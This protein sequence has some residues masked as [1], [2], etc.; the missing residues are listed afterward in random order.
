MCNKFAGPMFAS[1]RRGNTAPFEEMSQE[2]RDRGNTVSDLIGT[3]FKP[4]TPAAKT[5]TLPLDQQLAFS[6]N[7]LSQN[8]FVYGKNRQSKKKHCVQNS[9]SFYNRASLC[10][11]HF[12]NDFQS[13]QFYPRHLAAPTVR[14]T[15]QKH[16]KC[17]W[18]FTSLQI[19]HRHKK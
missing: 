1:L 5:D 13:L 7:S 15:L 17:L 14:Q 8:I 12:F 19:D 2:Y 4:H 11:R 3:R 10:W 9:C 18:N 6:K 16:L